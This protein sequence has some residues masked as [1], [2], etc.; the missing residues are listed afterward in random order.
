MFLQ[1]I[2]K[3]YKI[4]EMAYLL[5]KVIKFKVDTL[6]HTL[7]SNLKAFIPLSVWYF[8]NLCSECVNNCFR[9]H[10]SLTTHHLL[11]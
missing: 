2:L 10:K 8:R 1:S 7:K 4:L 9:R 3:K 6:L 5:V 11:F